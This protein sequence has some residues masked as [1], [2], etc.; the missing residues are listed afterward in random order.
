MPSVIFRTLCSIAFVHEQLAPFVVKHF[1]QMAVCSQLFSTFAAVPKHCYAPVQPLLGP[2][3]ILTRCRPSHSLTSLKKLRLDS[4]GQ[5]RCHPDVS[6]G[7]MRQL[8][9]ISLR[10]CRLG[11]LGCLDVSAGPQDPQGECSWSFS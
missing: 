9:D 2:F 11:S 5:L 3:R 8:D 1:Q 4:C 10:Q 6:R 7:L